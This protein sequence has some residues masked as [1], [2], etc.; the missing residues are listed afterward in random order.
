MFKNKQNMGKMDSKTKLID[1]A[2]NL[3]EIIKS[4]DDRCQE[5]IDI[6]ESTENLL[7][8]MDEKL[9]SDDE[10]N[11]SQADFI[12]TIKKNHDILRMREER[13]YLSKLSS[14]IKDVLVNLEK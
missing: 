14:R 11:V 5:N 1:V 2:L 12:V 6:I 4:I 7:K 13:D 3:N 8:R 9:L 10:N